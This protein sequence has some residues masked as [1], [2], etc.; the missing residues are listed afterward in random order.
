[1]TWDMELGNE[2][3]IR[4]DEL[5]VEEG[6]CETRSQAR[7]WILG[8]KVFVGGEVL[9]KPGKLL[10]RGTVFS[11]VAQSIYVS[12]GGEKLEAFLDEFGISVFGKTALDVG[13]ST[14][15]FTDCLLQRGVSSVVCFDVG[16][17]Q[18]HEKLLGDVRVRNFEKMNARVVTLEELGGECFDIMVIDLSFISLKKVL[19]NLWSFLKPGGICIALIKPQFESSREEVRHGQGII[20]DVKIHERV[21]NEVINFIEGELDLSKII[22]W[23]P[24]PIEGGEGNKEFLVGFWKEEI[25]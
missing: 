20:R 9:R 10:W 21:V 19:G 17:G 6:I 23:I 5:L 25:C 22:G 15:G 4:A 11:I 1:M 24:S 3:K 14:G 18:L 7:N 2:I 12:R 16:H 8:R 13:A